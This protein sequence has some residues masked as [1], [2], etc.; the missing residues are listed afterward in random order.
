M[1]V[2]APGSCLQTQVGDGDAVS[3]EDVSS[4]EHACVVVSAR[5]HEDAFL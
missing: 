3:L 4:C 1:G 2:L 5:Y